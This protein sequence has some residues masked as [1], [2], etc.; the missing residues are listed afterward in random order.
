MENTGGRQIFERGLEV[1]VLTLDGSVSK[2]KYIIEPL[3][4]TETATTCV[5]V[6]ADRKGHVP[7]KEQGTNR[8]LKVH[9]R[10]ILGIELHGKVI[11]LESNGKY[12]ACCP[13]CGNVFKIEPSDDSIICQTDGKF[14]LYWIGER[15]VE[16]LKTK[17][18][19]P[20][21][22]K[23]EPKAKAVK[24]PVQEPVKI[25][26]DALVKLPDCEVWTKKNVAFDHPGVNVQA[27]VLLLTG[28]K[29]RKL[30]FNSYDGTLGKK[31]TSLPTEAFIAGQT[32]K[33]GF[34]IK[35][36]EKEQ[37]TLANKGYER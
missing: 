24:K 1:C 37:T 15:P 28:D 14:E 19:T 5:T 6:R 36:V 34:N 16:T 12:R 33:G 32:V 29:P 30:C 18:N 22:A 9:F 31:A 35:D 27:H 13:V 23:K 7:L 11:V 4:E 25:D 17:P 3:S 21:T 26:F 20:K 10:R 2:E 8:E